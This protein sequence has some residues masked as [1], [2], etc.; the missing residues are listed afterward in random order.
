MKP[1]EMPSVVITFLKCLTPLSHNVFFFGGY[2]YSLTSVSVSFHIIPNLFHL[3]VSDYVVTVQ[4]FCG[5]SLHKGESVP[6]YD[7][8]QSIPSRV[9][10]CVGCGFYFIANTSMIEV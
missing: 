4:R 5:I 9:N 6:D 1:E 2:Y 8:T 7:K 3:T 10:A